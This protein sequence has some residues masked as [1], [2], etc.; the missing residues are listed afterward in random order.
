MEAD[1]RKMQT[2]QDL[3]EMKRQLSEKRDRLLSSLRDIDAKLTGVK[4][5]IALFLE[6]SRATDETSPRALLLRKLKGMTQAKAIV[7][8]AQY[9]SGIL[10]AQEAKALMIHAGIMRETRNSTSI[11]HKL[12]ARSDMFSRVGRG[13]YRLKTVADEPALTR[14]DKTTL[15]QLSITSK[16]IQ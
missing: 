9:N 15:N 2:L 12:I 11:V 14:A 13:R 10:S 4:T 1:Q 8:I 3:T 7:E 5:T 16:P 6:G